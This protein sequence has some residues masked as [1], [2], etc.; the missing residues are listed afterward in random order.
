MA[1]SFPDATSITGQAVA[2]P[3]R[4]ERIWADRHA[5]DVARGTGFGQVQLAT[6]TAS[7]GSL[8]SP[9]FRR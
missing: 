5:N 6:G 2:T 9:S 3:R 4:D 1:G 8:D 7:R